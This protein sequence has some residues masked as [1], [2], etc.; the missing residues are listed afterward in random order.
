MVIFFL[1]TGAVV[2]LNDFSKGCLCHLPVRGSRILT[3]DI[4]VQ[5]HA[6]DIIQ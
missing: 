2:I 3:V 5:Y 6:T 4:V 1:D